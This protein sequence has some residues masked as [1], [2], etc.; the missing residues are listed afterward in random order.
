MKYNYPTINKK[1]KKYWLISCNDYHEF[2]GFLEAYRKAG[3]NCKYKE[4]NGVG[5]V[6]CFY[7]GK[8]PK[9]FIKNVEYDLGSGQPG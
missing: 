9:K 3:I 5:Y 4:L 6:V 1:I 7:I 2:G 8:E